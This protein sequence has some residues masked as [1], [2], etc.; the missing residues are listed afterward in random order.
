MSYFSLPRV[1]LHKKEE[2]KKLNNLSSDYS[3]LF[4]KKQAKDVDEDLPSVAAQ[5]IVAEV[6]L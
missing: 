6:N 4:Y 2:V 3:H 1:K 5:Q